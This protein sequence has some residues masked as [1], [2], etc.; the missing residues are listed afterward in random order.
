MIPTVFERFWIWRRRA[1]LNQYDA[2]LTIG[3]S[4]GT[5]QLMERGMAWPHRWIEDW[6]LPHTLSPGEEVRIL[7]RRAGVTAEEFAGVLGVGRSWLYHIENNE[8]S[9]SEYEMEQINKAVIYHR[10][11]G[12][13][14]KSVDA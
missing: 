7:R 14:A 1:G 3:C 4:R 12:F 8:L 5:V 13:W 6:Q 10:K 2:A 11:R 9:L